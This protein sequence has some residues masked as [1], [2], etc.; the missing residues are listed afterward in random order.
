MT[1]NDKAK[2]A[3]LGLEICDRC[4][5]YESQLSHR[6]SPDEGRIADAISREASEIP[7]TKLGYGHGMLT[8]EISE[9]IHVRF[10]IF[11]RT[12]TLREVYCLEDLS[13][14]QAARIVRAIREIVDP[15]SQKP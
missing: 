11:M 14:E 10:Q 3:E 15:E 6:C 2:A 13:I 4:G 8:F 9:Q 5:W 7:S 1:K 12:I